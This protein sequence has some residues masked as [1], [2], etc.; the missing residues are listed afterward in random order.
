MRGSLK[1]RNQAV[2][3][4]GER[5]YA[6]LTKSAAAKLNMGVG[7]TE[8]APTYTPEIGVMFRF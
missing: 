1:K 4:I 2:S 7:V 6:T 5:Q 8:K 3:L